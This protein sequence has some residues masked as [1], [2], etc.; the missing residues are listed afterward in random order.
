[1]TPRT[2]LLALAV[3]LSSSE[4]LADDAL[5]TVRAAIAPGGEPVRLTATSGGRSPGITL[6]VGKGKPSRLYAGEAIGTVKV[7]HGKAVVAFAVDDAAAPFRVHVVGGKTVFLSTHVL[8]EAERLC[9][10]IVGIV[11]GR[12]VA[13]GPPADI[14]ARSGA[15]SF[16]DAFL[17]LVAE[18]TMGA[19]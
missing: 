16:R 15:A 8:D 3:A 5:T 4:V 14:V 7:G 1:M 12:T 9:D 11:G 19:A 13:E 17:A 6:R 10:N 18:G 2:A